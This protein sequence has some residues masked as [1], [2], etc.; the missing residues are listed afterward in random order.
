MAGHGTSIGGIIVDSGKF[1]LTEYRARVRNL[2]EPEV[3]YHGIVYIEALCP[4]AFI[5]RAR[6][7]A[8]ERGVRTL[9]CV[10]NATIY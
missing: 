7:A 1:H 8:P 9:Q 6:R 10:S 2:N 3:S 5:G 4:A